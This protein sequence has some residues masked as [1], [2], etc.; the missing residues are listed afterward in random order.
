MLEVQILING[1]LF[2]RIGIIR[3]DRSTFQ[4]QTG[5]IKS[6][7]ETNLRKSRYY[8]FQFQTGA[9]K[10]GTGDS[11]LLMSREFQFQTGAIKRGVL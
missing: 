5:A 3:L 6:Q 9:I 1:S 11:G 4:F 8:V 10:S 7:Y 2:I